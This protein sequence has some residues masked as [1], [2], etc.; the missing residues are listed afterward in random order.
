MKTVDMQTEI[1]LYFRFFCALHCISDI[2]PNFLA[3]KKSGM[4]YAFCQKFRQMTVM[5]VTEVK[6]MEKCVKYLTLAPIFWQP[7]N[8][9]WHQLPFPL[10]VLNRKSADFGA[11]L[12]RPFY[13]SWPLLVTYKQTCLDKFEQV[14][15]SLRKLRQVWNF[16]DSL[17][18]SLNKC[19]QALGKFRQLLTKSKQIWMSLN[20]L[21]CTVFPKIV[22]PALVSNL[23][24]V[25][26][27]IKLRR[28][29][30]LN[31]QDE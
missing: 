12:P 11:F 23:I 4:P 28:E 20:Y 21:R 26:C 29:S 15:T 5:M 31:V 22:T 27:S 19:R 13:V 30:K 7:V 24:L 25:Q 16:F 18:T 14:K 9:K 10:S 2:S 8:R 17:Y 6:E 3:K 1:S